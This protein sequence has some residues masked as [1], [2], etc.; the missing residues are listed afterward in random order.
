[1][2]KEGGRGIHPPVFVDLKQLGFSCLFL[3]ASPVRSVAMV[4]V[5]FDEVEA[6]SPLS[7]RRGPVRSVFVCPVGCRR[8]ARRVVFFWF[9][10]A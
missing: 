5:V 1:M 8:Y 2:K 9:E 10:S 3:L 4:W 7:I 6:L